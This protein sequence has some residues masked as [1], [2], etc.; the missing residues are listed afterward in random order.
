MPFPTGAPHM[1][2]TRLHALACG[3]ALFAA[4]CT[5]GAQPIRLGELNSYKTFP[6]FLEAYKKGM[7]LALD[8]V[9]A[10]GGVIGRKLELVSRDD[11]G[12]PGDAVRVAEELISR[13][14]VTMLM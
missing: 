2:R 4:A 8:E 9:N 11:T 3:F 10:G 14:K 1:N 6:A 12:A 13:E 5:L 7:E